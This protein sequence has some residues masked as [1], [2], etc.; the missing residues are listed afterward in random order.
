LNSALTTNSQI[1]IGVSNT[2]PINTNF[3]FNYSVK[4]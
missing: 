1:F 3:Q 2:V 4:Q